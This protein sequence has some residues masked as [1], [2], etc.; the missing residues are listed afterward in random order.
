MQKRRSSS[1]SL[2]ITRAN[3]KVDE[4]GN[5]PAFSTSHHSSLQKT[6]S[7]RDIE[8][9]AKLLAMD[10]DMWAAFQRHLA[11]SGVKTGAGTKV[12]L[13]KFVSEWMVQ[14]RTTEV[15]LEAQRQME[16]GAL[17]A[18]RTKRVSSSPNL[19]LSSS[20]S[21]KGNENSHPS[22]DAEGGGNYLLRRHTIGRASSARLARKMSGSF[23]GMLVG[24]ES[25]L[26]SAN[27]TWDDSLATSSQQREEQGNAKDTVVKRLSCSSATYSK[28]PSLRVSLSSRLSGTSDSMSN[29]A[30]FVSAMFGG[31]DDDH[32]DDTIGEEQ[33]EDKAVELEVIKQMPSPQIL[34]A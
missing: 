5:A 27:A 6:P 14:E 28:R 29:A 12:V 8:Q 32:F 24:G 34:E 23:T 20:A 9:K 1:G 30:S 17:S 13:Q 7:Q 21:Q 25:Q 33:E 15:A 3:I 31:L 19:R 16:K 18:Q 10:D 4:D 2:Q 22:E 11:E 26:Q